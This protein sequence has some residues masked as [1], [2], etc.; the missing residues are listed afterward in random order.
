MFKSKNLSLSL[1]LDALFETGGNVLRFFFT[2]PV[3][4]FSTIGLLIPPLESL[5]LLF[6]LSSLTV[7]QSQK[8]IAYIFYPYW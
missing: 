8:V 3:G 4:F 2:T 1:C 5:F 6:S 7:L